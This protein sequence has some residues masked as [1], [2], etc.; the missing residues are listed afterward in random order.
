MAVSISDYP[1]VIVGSGFYG[2]TVAR[3]IA[4]IYGVEVLLID[5]RAHAGGNSFSKVDDATGIEYHAYGSHIF[6]TS[7]EAVWSFITQFTTF[8]QYRHRVVTRHKD[9]IYSMPIN[10]LTINAFFERGLSPGEARDLLAG[11][12]RIWK[13]RRFP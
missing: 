13:K 6:H 12:M 2:A 9:R 5:K 1:V 4:T 7:S 8:N 3:Q 10:L 11:E